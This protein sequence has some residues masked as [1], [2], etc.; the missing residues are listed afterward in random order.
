[1]RGWEVSDGTRVRRAGSD[2]PGSVRRRGAGG[3]PRVRGGPKAWAG[4]FRWGR[5]AVRGTG[6]QL[7][8]GQ[9]ERRVSLRP[10]GGPTRSASAQGIEDTEAR[11]AICNVARG[12]PVLPEA[13]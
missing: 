5:G 7:V 11:W 3:L 1:M 8:Q 2:D 10:A 6:T 4:L 12:F 9:M 13:S